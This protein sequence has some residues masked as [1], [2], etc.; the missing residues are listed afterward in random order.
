MSGRTRVELPVSSAAGAVSR[1]HTMPH[2]RPSRIHQLVHRHC[3]RDS[4]GVSAPEIYGPNPPEPTSVPSQDPLTTA[5]SVATRTHTTARQLPRDSSRR[6]R[7]KPTLGRSRDLSKGKCEAAYN[8]STPAPKVRRAT[9]R[10]ASL[11]LPESYPL[12]RY[13]N[14]ALDGPNAPHVHRLS[15]T[16]CP[17]KVHCNPLPPSNVTVDRLSEVM[18]RVSTVGCGAWPIH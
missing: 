7:S 5:A 13:G 18:S 16:P 4:T 3:R 9:R 15:N 17:P 8:D 2:R 11:R 6:R 12:P 10:A 1:G 14:E